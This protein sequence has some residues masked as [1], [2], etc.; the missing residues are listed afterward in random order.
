MTCLGGVGNCC[1]PCI[2]VGTS[3]G[4][5]AVCFVY[6]TTMPAIVTSALHFPQTRTKSPNS[7]RAEKSV[8]L[9]LDQ[10]IL[11]GIFSLSPKHVITTRHEHQQRS[12][13]GIKCT[14]CNLH[15][16]I[17]LEKHVPFAN[18]HAA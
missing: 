17:A 8:C 5:P 9:I 1:G 18:F 2:S 7:T 13:R 3:G 6:R 14:Q 11:H 10:Q 16:P 15:R 4:A 12:R